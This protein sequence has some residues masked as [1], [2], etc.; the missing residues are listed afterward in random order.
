MHCKSSGGAYQK[1]GT[2]D[3]SRTLAGP[4]QNRKT[5]NRDPGETGKTGYWTLAGPYKKLENQDP[6]P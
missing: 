6:G 2:Q 3:F 4:Y 5:G 1:T